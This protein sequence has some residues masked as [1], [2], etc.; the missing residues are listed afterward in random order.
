[1]KLKSMVNCFLTTVFICSC[2][3]TAVK[4]NSSTNVVQ[5]T[6][7]KSNVSAELLKQQLRQTRQVQASFDSKA[8]K[9]SADFNAF[10]AA[11]KIDLVLRDIDVA[12]VLR[13]LAKE[14]HKNIVIDES[15]Q[16]TINADL[17]RVSLNEAM[18]TILTSQE[19]ESRVQNSTIY[20]ASRPAMARKGLNRKYIKAFRL[21]NANA[22]EVASILD[23][24]IFNKGYAVNETSSSSTAQQ[25]AMQAVADPNQAAAQPTTQTAQ[26]SSTGQSVLVSSKTIRGKVETVTEGLDFN[27]SSKPASAIKLQRATSASENIIVN[28]NDNGAIV[29]PDTRTN[30]VLIAGLEED[31]LLAQE[32][33]NYLDKPLRQVSIEVSLIEIKKDDTNNLGLAIADRG[34]KMTIGFNSL[35]D[36]SGFSTV[37]NQT[38]LGYNSIK[39]ISDNF[40]VRLNA[41][42]SNNKAKL[43]ANPN[44]VALDGSESLI[45]ITDRIVSNLQVTTSQ[46]VTTYNTELEDIGIVLNILPRIADND[47]ITMRVRPSITS[48]LA[49]IQIGTGDN[50][51]EITPVSTREIIIQDVRIKAGETLAIGGLIK[52]NDI[53]QIGRLPYASDLPVFGA[54]FKNKVKTHNKTEIYI[55][56]TPKII[57]DVAS[58]QL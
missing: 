24:S 14:G 58:Q 26:G 51:T 18:Q 31:I 9:L 39:T 11:S 17:K 30:S 56:I 49:N 32:A 55:L 57:A 27:D 28:N 10:P 20:V 54:L 53:E 5:S 21:N 48:P 52:E 43:L 41:L 46:G 40:A 13:L 37:A 36:I 44:I 16:G 33:I 12:S 34:G 2:M 42:I 7:N 23:A 29:I 1:M 15:V 8:L 19:L 4:A 47:Y 25:P 38:G 35:S 6:N 50:G 45:K 3:T 22:V